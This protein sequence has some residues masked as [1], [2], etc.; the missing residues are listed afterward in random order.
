VIAEVIEQGR[1]TCCAP[2][3]LRPEVPL[4][5]VREYSYL[6]GAIGPHDG[7]LDTLILPDVNAEAIALF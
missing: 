6:F 5:I 4:Q 1:R 2:E 3:G 7:V